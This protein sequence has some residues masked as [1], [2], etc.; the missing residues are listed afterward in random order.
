MNDKTKRNGWRTTAYNERFH[1]SGGV[2]PQ[3][4]LWEFG[5]LSPARTFVN[6]R[7]REAATALGA[8]GARQQRKRGLKANASSSSER[9]EHIKEQFRK[10]LQKHEILLNS[11]EKPIAVEKWRQNFNVLRNGKKK[12]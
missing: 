12:K 7:L 9:A 3:T 8:S 6:P 5:S 4:V 11:T 10:P 1:A 2:C